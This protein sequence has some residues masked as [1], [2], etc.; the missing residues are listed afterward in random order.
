MPDVIKSRRAALRLS[1]ADLAQRAGVDR[2]QIRRY[3]SGETQP[4][5][6]VARALAH[7]LGISIDEL[8]GDEP[9]RRVDLSGEWWACWQTWRNGEEVANPHLVKIVQNGDRL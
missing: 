1:Q 2:R 3:E 5:L 7:A 8:A 9:T 6:G 4:N